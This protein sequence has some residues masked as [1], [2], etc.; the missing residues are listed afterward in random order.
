MEL[1][2]SG[3]SDGDGDDDEY[4]PR[5]CKK[6]RS[7]RLMNKRISAALDAENVSDYGAMHILSAVVQALGHSISEFA[8]SRPTIRRAR[9]NYRKEIATEVKQNF[10]VQ[11]N[12]IVVNE[13]MIHISI[14]Y[15]HS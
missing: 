12:A 10:T 8:L 3:E 13:K 11:K 14:Y 4:V 9:I 7:K 5:Q 2:Y 6:R 1:E 15:F